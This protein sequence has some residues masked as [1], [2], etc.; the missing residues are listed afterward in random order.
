MNEHQAS[1][2]P[3]KCSPEV[4][5]TVTGCCVT[6]KWSWAVAQQWGFAW[7]VKG[8]GSIP[9]TTFNDSCQRKSVLSQENIPERWQLR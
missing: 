6:V 3:E 7:N 1:E 9:S 4:E 8:P 2:L 5:I